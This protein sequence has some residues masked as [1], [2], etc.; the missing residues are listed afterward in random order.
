[1]KKNYLLFGIIFFTLG[2]C[3]W[4]VEPSSPDVKTYEL[5]P[6][7][8]CTEMACSSEKPC[9]NSCQ[10]NGWREKESGILAQSSGEPLPGCILNGCGICP[11]TLQASGYFDNTEKPSMF[12][13]TE[14]K[15]V[16]TPISMYP[17]PPPI[18]PNQEEK[19]QKALRTWMQQLQEQSNRE[20][21]KLKQEDPVKYEQMQNAI[22]LFK[23]AV[24][25]NNVPSV[26]AVNE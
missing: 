25:Q 1:M 7:T 17:P 26:P 22:N 23:N 11:F 18:D 3:A 13:V 15:T 5:I 12:Y 16:E 2:S 21:E 6:L 19:R 4:A 20:M 14:W 10:L 9:C 8:S 24:Q